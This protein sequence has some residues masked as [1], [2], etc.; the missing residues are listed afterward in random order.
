LE[1]EVGIPSINRRA[2][3]VLYNRDDLDGDVGLAEIKV[4]GHSHVY[5]RA[6]QGCSLLAMER[7]VSLN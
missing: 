7:P 6:S 2:D 4:S 3:L 5:G 1:W